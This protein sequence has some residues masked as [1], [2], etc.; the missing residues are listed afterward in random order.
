MSQLS[1]ISL[2]IAL[3][4]GLATWGFLAVGGV[5]IWAAFVAWGCFFHTGGDE[6]ALRNTLIGNAFGVLLAWGAALVILAVPMA[7]Q[8]GLP[9]WAGLVVGASVW[10]LCSAARIKAFSVIPASVYGYA[11]AFAFLLQTP[12][13]LSL[14]KLLAP[15]LDNALL[16]VPLSMSIGAVLGY[17]SAKLGGLLAG[18]GKPA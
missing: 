1:A 4:G 7:G 18:A 14:A 6:A 11:S 5:F 12:D 17:I 15:N 16:V 3:L 8:L 9:L 2:S 10:L 13:K